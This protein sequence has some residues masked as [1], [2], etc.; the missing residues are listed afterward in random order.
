MMMINKN[1]H[2]PVLL[3][4]SVDGLNIIEDGVYVDV[5]FGGGGHS[6]EILS[7]LGQKGRLI[8]FDQ[9]KDSKMNLINDN[10]LVLIN[11]NFMYLKKFLK[12]NNILKVDGI[13]ADFG[14][15][16]HQID[17]PDRGFSYRFNSD[18]DMRMDNN[19]PLSASHILNKYSS[20]D[21]N[22]IFKEYGELNNSSK[23]T[24]AIITSRKKKNIKTTFEL[25]DIITP[26]ISKRNSNKILSRIYQAIR[27][28]V[29]NEL[30]V[31]KS[32][33]QQSLELLKIGGRICLISYHSLEDRIVKRFVKKGKFEGEIEKDIYGNFSLPY[34]SIGKLIVPSQTEINRN[35]RA[36]SAKLRIAERVQV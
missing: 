35:I 16:S 4:E 9:D 34:K 28:E 30:G 27:I 25:N 15:S 26:F 19:N 3:K 18:L 5:T 12:L 24:R 2:T 36:R 14:I 33:L 7:R 17:K 21:L 29:N 11:E 1:Y 20:E 32:L 10:R 6:K 13:L 31:I 8:A 22:K 23:I